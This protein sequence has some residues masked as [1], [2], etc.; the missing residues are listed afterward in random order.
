MKE[1]KEFEKNLAQVKIP[2]LVLDQKWHQLF[3]LSGKPTSILPLEE[4]LKRLVERQ[5][6]LNNDLKDLKK[7]KNK[8]M[9][10]IVQNME[11]THEEHANDISSKKLKE[12]RRLIDEINEKME[13]YEDELLELPKLI[14]E[15]NRKLML[16]TMDFSYDRLR[17]NKEEIDE[18]GAWINQVRIDLKKNVIKKQNR[19]INNK[20]IYSYMHDIFGAQVLDIFD[21]KEESEQQEQTEEK[22]EE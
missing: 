20:Q 16:E 6:K 8:L 3:A 12:D 22:K 15:A 1:Q 10:N 7:T 5:G 21:I 17:T 18:I 2:L 13:A 4:E 9:E 14:Q 19:E 11:G